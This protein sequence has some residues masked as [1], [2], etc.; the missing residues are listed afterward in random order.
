MPNALAAARQQLATPD[1]E[2]LIS[3]LVPMLALIGAAGMNA[4]DREEWLVAAADALRGIP[5]DIFRRC[6]ASARI[7]VDHPAKLV[8]FVLR[9]AD[10]EWARRRRNVDRLEW[11]SR[12]STRPPAP[13]PLA[14]PDEVAEI[15]ERYG[16]KSKVQPRDRKP[17]TV[18]DY[19][20]L[21]HS[22]ESAEKFVA[23]YHSKPDAQKV[24]AA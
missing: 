3:A 15:L 16:L 4:G 10:T 18:E 24:R 2:D 20:S 13:E 17:P 7:S 21:G 6:L 12:L 5:T 1:I 23:Q 9:E 14:T 19:M 8:S 11:L 22:R